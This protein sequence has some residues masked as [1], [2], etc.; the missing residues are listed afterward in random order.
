M[1][2]EPPR[3]QWLVQS[4]NLLT[5]AATLSNLESANGLTENNNITSENA[6]SILLQLM[7]DLQDIVPEVLLTSFSL[8][9]FIKLH[10]KFI[11]SFECL[12]RFVEVIDKFV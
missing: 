11:F 9:L 6:A 7:D 4:N 10:G 5:A 2:P 3:P 1:D 8:P 12:S